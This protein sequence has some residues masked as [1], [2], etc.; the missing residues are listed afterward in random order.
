MT[1]ETRS[2]DISQLNESFGNYL[3]KSKLKISVQSLDYLSDIANANTC[4]NFDLTISWKHFNQSN[5]RKS[6]Y[7]D[8]S[9]VINC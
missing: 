8:F 9:N 1:K 3:D 5:T 6:R 7:I 2:L 4:N